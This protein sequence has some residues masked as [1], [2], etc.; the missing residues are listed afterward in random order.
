MFA[1]NLDAMIKK[2]GF[3]SSESFSIFLDEQFAYK[4]S[5]ESITKY[6]NGTRTPDPEFIEIALK[7][8]GEDASALFGG[9]QSNIKFVPIVGSAS[10][11]VPLPNSYQD[12]ENKAFCRSEVWNK[13]LYA[14]IA[15]GESM[16]PEI[17][18]EDEVICDP[19]AKIL[20]GDMVHYQ[21][22]G[23][24]AI[25]VYYEDEAIGVIEFVPFNQNGDYKT[26]KFRVDDESVDIR[27]SKVVAINK[28]KTNNRAAR[29]KAINRG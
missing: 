2:A 22:G 18:N 25:K 6:R 13:E 26:L 10:C 29:L 17:D 5:K 12:I 20:S 7:A 1:S 9:Q 8:M 28:S 24:S 19:S 14:V 3:P 16:T 15:D 21:V 27:M 11:G 4:I 23:E